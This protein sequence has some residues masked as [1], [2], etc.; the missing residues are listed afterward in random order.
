MAVG[1]FGFDQPHTYVREKGKERKTLSKTARTWMLKP[2][3]ITNGQS[4]FQKRRKWERDIS[5]E[6]KRRGSQQTKRTYST[7]R[8]SKRRRVLSSVRRAAQA[9]CNVSTKKTGWRR[10]GVKSAAC[11]IELERIRDPANRGREL[12][13]KAEAHRSNQERGA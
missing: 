4:V 8:A 7:E 3:Q 13:R 12:E 11:A 1:L 9:K 6:Q 5:G 10:S 2:C